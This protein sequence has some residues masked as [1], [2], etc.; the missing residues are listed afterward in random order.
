M[1]DRWRAL[2]PNRGHP[3]TDITDLRAG[4]LPGRKHIV[5]TRFNVHVP[6]RAGA[7]DEAWLRDRLRWFELFT[8]PSI[9][10]QTVKPDC[11]MIFC[12]AASPEWLLNRMPPFA[13]VR[14]VRGIFTAAVA[15]ESVSSFIG[16][17]IT[18][19]VDND[20]AIAI[21]YLEA[22]QR[23]APVEGYVNFMH[24]LQLSGERLYRRSDPSN[25]FI[26]RAEA[27]AYGTVFAQPHRSII[28]GHS[29]RQVKG[30]P[31][32]LQVVHDRN[33]ANAAIGI[34]T[35][36]EHLRRF[37]VDAHVSDRGIRVDRI[38]SAMR[39]AGRVICRPHRLVWALR[40][41]RGNRT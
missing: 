30:A 11:W 41:I 28:E 20:D 5:M 37:A 24:G 35:S 17:L 29:V 8:V 6:E 10:A 4:G 33:W 40:V 18:T 22:V 39:V 25:A 19:R 9:M 36:G 32:W 23:E 3:A 2:P 16:P 15:A 13:T 27:Q 34:R 21:D 1:T 14:P 7:P 12:D 31:M 26:S 38:L